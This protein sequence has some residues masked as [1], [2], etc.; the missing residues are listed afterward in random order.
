MQSARYQKRKVQLTS[1]FEKV[2]EFKEEFFRLC[3]E[4]E[5]RFRKSVSDEGR[6]LVSL[7][8]VGLEE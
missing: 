6:K 5:L 4:V 1:E 3:V 7:S 2:S 8:V